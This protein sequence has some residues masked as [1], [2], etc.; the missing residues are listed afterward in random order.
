MKHIILVLCMLFLCMI[1]FAYSS[2]LNGILVIGS[3]VQR[4]SLKTVDGISADL[5]Y[6]IELYTD[7]TNKQYCLRLTFAESNKNIMI[8]TYGTLLLKT[9]NDEV[10]EL[11]AL[12]SFN[13]ESRYDTGLSYFPISEEQLEM[14]ISNKI[15][16]M[17]IQVIAEADHHNT[18]GEKEWRIDDLGHSIKQMISEVDKQCEKRMKKYISSMADLKA[19]F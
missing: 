8:P 13:K 17:R 7:G 11:K 5:F 18:I 2:I 19:D 16:K 3:D 14:I 9:M 10:I 12:Y 15:K 4:F 6:N 1:S